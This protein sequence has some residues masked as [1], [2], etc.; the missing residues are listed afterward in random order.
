VRAFSGHTR[1]FNPAV[2]PLDD[3]FC[4]DQPEAGT[5]GIRYHSIPAPK[6][7][8]EK[9]GLFLPAHSNP[10]IMNHYLDPRLGPPSP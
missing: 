6:K 8:G 9:L 2:V 1:D 7:L 5:A 10:G 4:D 3:C